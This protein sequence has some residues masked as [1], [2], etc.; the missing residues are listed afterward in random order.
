MIKDAPCTSKKSE[1]EMGVEHLQGLISFPKAPTYLSRAKNI[2]GVNIP[3]KRE[4]P[5]K[6]P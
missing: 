1:W 3:P 6:F 2:L 5:L 4:H